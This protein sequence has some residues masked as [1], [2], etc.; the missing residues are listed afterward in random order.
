MGVKAYVLGNNECE[1]QMEQTLTFKGIS[2]LSVSDTDLMLNLFNIY[3]GFILS[4]F[5]SIF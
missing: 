3:L 4:L 2:S 5:S 1:C